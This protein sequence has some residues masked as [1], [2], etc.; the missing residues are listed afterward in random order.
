[1]HFED[2]QTL[3]WIHLDFQ[4]HPTEPTFQLH[5][6]SILKFFPPEPSGPPKIKKRSKSGLTTNWRQVHI[7]PLL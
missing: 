7:L 1:M 2:I 6:V 4:L 5:R 3:F